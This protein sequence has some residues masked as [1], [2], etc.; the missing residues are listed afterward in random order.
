M[1]EKSL[2]KKSKCTKLA[3][4]AFA[5][6]GIL[7]NFSCGQYTN[8]LDSY[9]KYWT[10]IARSTSNN[11]EILAKQNAPATEGKDEDKIYCLSS[12]NNQTLEFELDNP[13]NFTLVD[14]DGL[15]SFNID[16]K[17][18]DAKKGTDYTY[19]ITNTKLSLILKKAFLEKYEQ[20]VNNSSTLISLT[21]KLKADD[22]RIFPEYKTEF[23]INTAPP[24]PK[25]I[26]TAQTTTQPY[27]LVL[28]IAFDSKDIGEKY[29]SIDKKN[30]PCIKI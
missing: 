18:I 5:L 24:C 26:I 19:N 3:L 27:K 13:Q 14:Y 17:K 4:I 2:I 7:S 10:S 30:Q 25:E 6:V 1:K 11:I 22:G 29:S 16:A 28:C 21:I 23:S 20:G 9:F 12:Q 15:I 8:D